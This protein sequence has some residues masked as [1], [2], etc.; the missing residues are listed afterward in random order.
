MEQIDRKLDI[1]FLKHSFE[2]I[3]INMFKESFKNEKFWPKKGNHRKESNEN[4]RTK[5]HYM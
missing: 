5:N 1:R 2:I 4:S 3:I